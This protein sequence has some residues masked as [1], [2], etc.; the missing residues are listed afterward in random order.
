LRTCHLQ[1]PAF[2]S[3]VRLIDTSPLPN[4]AQVCWRCLHQ[5]ANHQPANL[6]F[7]GAA[8][9]K[10]ATAVRLANADTLAATRRF[11]NGA[12]RDGWSMAKTDG[13]AAVTARSTTFAATTPPSTRRTTQR[14]TRQTPAALRVAMVVLN[15]VVTVALLLSRVATA[16][17]LSKAMV[18][19]SKSMLTGVA[20]VSLP[21]LLPYGNV[22]DQGSTNARLVGGGKSNA[23]NA[24]HRVLNARRATSS[25]KATSQSSN[26][27]A[28]RKRK[29]LWL[30]QSE[31]TRSFHHCHL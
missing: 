21:L 13:Y 16:A 23:M 18:S 10:V 22:D 17:L 20:K 7:R 31:R 28:A 14:T 24:N 9:E 29:R 6:A 2:A 26:G 15:R 27:E 25:V 1:S 19:T 8:T 5:S 11:P 3:A 4:V 30:W 12:Y